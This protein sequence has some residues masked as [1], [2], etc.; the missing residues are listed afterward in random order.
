MKDPVF[1]GVFLISSLFAMSSCAHYDSRAVFR[2]PDNDCRLE[3]SNRFDKILLVD[4]NA[5]VELTCRGQGRAHYLGHTDWFYADSAVRWDAV[6]KNVRVVLCSRFGGAPIHLEFGLA[7]AKLL[8]ADD[9]PMRKPLAADL[10][11]AG[12]PDSEAGVVALPAACPLR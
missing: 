2:S 10:S 8:V 4:P 3:I 11:K 1:A 7:P 12:R 5:Y 6:R 9:D